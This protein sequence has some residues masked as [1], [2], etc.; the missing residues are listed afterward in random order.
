MKQEL[1]KT[2]TKTCELDPGAKDRQTEDKWD[3]IWD[4]KGENTGNTNINLT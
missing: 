3:D 1:T 2:R 4:K